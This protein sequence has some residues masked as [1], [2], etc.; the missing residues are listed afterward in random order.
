M[1]IGR[2]TGITLLL[3]ILSLAGLLAI[4]IAAW[5][6]EWTH[7]L[8]VHRV[9]F[10]L[11]AVLLF[12][13]ISRAV[14]RAADG[15]HTGR[16]GW[17][18]RLRQFF[19]AET[20]E[21][22]RE[23]DLFAAL[24]HLVV[25]LLLPLVLLQIWGL[26]DASFDMLKQFA[27]TGFPIGQV[28]IVP[29]QLLLGALLLII[30]TA[31]IRWFTSRMETKWLARTPMES[32]TRE[33]VATLT[34]YVLFVIA[35]MIVLSYAG[36]DLSKLALIAGALS[37]GIGFGLQTIVSNFVSGLILLFEQPIRRGNFVTVGDSEGF[38]RRIRIRATE[39]E[40]LNRVTVIVP[41]SEML[42]SHL[43]NWNL[44]DRFGRITCK[45][46]VAYGS[47]VRL[48]QSLLLAVAD[49]HREVI[50]DTNLGVPKPQALFLEFGDSTLNFE[51][52]CFIRDITRRF[53]V[54]SDL[55][56]AIDDT[57]KANDITIAFP[58]LDVWHRNTPS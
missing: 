54:I 19:H 41:N 58:Q 50:T 35:A 46:G 11:F 57:F 6:P 7:G 27:W 21:H 44:R 18:R 3:V 32:H 4:G 12:W 9:A 37:V 48:V 38:V 45:V 51:L 49:N 55:N 8:P 5:H 56:I 2:G 10:T 42:S 13:L 25:W 47:D 16:F 20:D 30:F 24:L 28:K 1:P 17:Q 33:A 43:Q 22:F 31:I 23:V 40:T 26:S 14:D 15:F 52:R 39:I 53:P 34:G 36:L 29:A